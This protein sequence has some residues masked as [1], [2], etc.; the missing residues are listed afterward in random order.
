[1]TIAATRSVFSILVCLTHIVFVFFCAFY[2]HS[3]VTKMET[4][5]STLATFLPIFGVYLGIVV[6]SLKLEKSSAPERIDNTFLAV[7]FILFLAYL[8]GN[9]AVIYAYGT[10][11]IP[12]EDLLPGAIGLVEAAFG[13]FFTTLF[14]TLFGVARKD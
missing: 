3:R 1:M 10:D 9:T 12:S 2:L 11:V 8:A 4:Y 5:F 7:L 6:K 14:L 13:G